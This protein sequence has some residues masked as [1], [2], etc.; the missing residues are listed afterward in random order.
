M[1]RWTMPARESKRQIG[2][3]G[4]DQACANLSGRACRCWSNWAGTQVH[5]IVPTTEDPVMRFFEG[6]LQR[7]EQLGVQPAAIS[8][9]GDRELRDQQA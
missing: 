7:P 8:D 3:R 4:E 2:V 5:K 1:R 6:S 9:A